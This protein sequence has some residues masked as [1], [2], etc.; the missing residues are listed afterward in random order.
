M[1]TDILPA[2][3][4]V[5]DIQPNAGPAW[6]RIELPNGT[7]IPCAELTGPEDHRIAYANLFSASIDMHARLSEARE[8]LMSIACQETDK[9]HEN[10]RTTYRDKSLEIQSVL[11]KSLG[12]K[13]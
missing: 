8:M 5:A 1:E 11:R 3:N 6:V 2:Y 13:S 9:L 7:L 12:M 10:Q 4:L